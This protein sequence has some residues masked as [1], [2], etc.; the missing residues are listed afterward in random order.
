MTDPED[1]FAAVLAKADWLRLALLD[2][3]D[4]NLSGGVLETRSGALRGSIR[5]AIDSGE[6]TIAVSLEST[7]VV[8]AGIQEHGGRTAA[9]D[10][11]ATKAQALRFAGLGGVIFASRVHNPGSA[12]PARSYLGSALADMRSDIQSTLKAAVIEILDAT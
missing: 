9:H 2:K 3:V 11:V 4:F 1:V 10:I 7:G 12:I 8:Y 5:S 6:S